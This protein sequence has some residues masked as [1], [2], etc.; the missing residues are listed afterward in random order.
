MST[1]LLAQAIELDRDTLP[2]RLER[3]GHTIAPT[4]HA[5]ED[6]E[7]RAREPECDDH[8]TKPAELPLLLAKTEALLGS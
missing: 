7:R 3:N 2:F 8:D 4:A 6:D 5:M 1:I